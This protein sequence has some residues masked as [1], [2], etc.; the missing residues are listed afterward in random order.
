MK[1]STPDPC[2]PADTAPP[3]V[4]EGTLVC[5]ICDAPLTMVAKGDEWIFADHDGQEWATTAPEGISSPQWWA[6]LA[7]ADPGLYSVLRAATDLLCT[8][9][10]HTH[11]PTG[12]VCVSP[13]PWCCCAPMQ[14]TPSGWRC[15]ETA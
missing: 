5:A 8:G 12:T 13:V 3:P 15:R 9:W 10:T 6:A 7:A 2:K 14:W 11:Q 4:I 1:R